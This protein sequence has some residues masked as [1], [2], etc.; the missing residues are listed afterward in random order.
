M[1]TA[2]KPD[3][4]EKLQGDGP[5][6]TTGPDEASPMCH[7]ENESAHADGEAEYAIIEELQKDCSTI[8]GELEA[9]RKEFSW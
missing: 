4:V 6:S 2:R 5:A 3:D 7:L 1:A 9:W 8:L